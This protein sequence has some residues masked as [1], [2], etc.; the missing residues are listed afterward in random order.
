[1]KLG[2]SKK[3]YI[4]LLVF[5]G[6]YLALIFFVIFPLVKDIRKN[7]QQL[8]LEEEARIVFSEEK[9]NF[10]NFKD[11]YQKIR[12][13]MKKTENFFASS[14]IEFIYFLEETAVNN[15]VLIEISSVSSAEGDPW[16]SLNFSLQASGS[17]SDFSRFI[18][19]L[20]NSTYLIEIHEISIRK[21][22]ERDKPAM[23]LGESITASFF[24]K[25]FKK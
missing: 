9:E 3:N 18:E 25:V 17:F 10:K 1:M 16:S 22:A 4:S 20:E 19:R 15:N 14:E 21:L 8:L 11:V 23:F 7:S 2:F 24:L 5:T 13:D 12:P 6:A